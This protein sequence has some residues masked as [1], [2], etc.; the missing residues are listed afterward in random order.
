MKV[1]SLDFVAS[2]TFGDV[3]SVSLA[4]LFSEFWTGFGVVGPDWTGL[5]AVFGPRLGLGAG[6]FLFCGSLKVI[7]IVWFA[8]HST[9]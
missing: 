9:V 6:R 1:A 7:N 8:S 4:K 5:L 2:L 3:S